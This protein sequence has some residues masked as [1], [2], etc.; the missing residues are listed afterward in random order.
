[1]S[2]LNLLHEDA[3][4]ELRNTTIFLLALLGAIGALGV[5]ALNKAD[6]KSEKVENKIET[7]ESLKKAQED[8]DFVEEYNQQI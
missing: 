6:F 3:K 7:K 1:M 5:W 2:Q 8:I 4:R